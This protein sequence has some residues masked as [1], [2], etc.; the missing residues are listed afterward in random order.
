MVRV[1]WP[2]APSVAALL[3]LGR[4]VPG[5]EPR[6]AVDRAS[7]VEAMASDRDVGQSVAILA[8]AGLATSSLLASVRRWAAEVDLLRAATG[9]VISTDRESALDRLVAAP[10]FASLRLR[11]L[12]PRHALVG[13]EAEFSRAAD[14]L[15]KGGFLLVSGVAPGESV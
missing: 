3:R 14:R 4:P 5:S 12:G 10:E 1:K 15:R 13:D 7:V 2:D 9:V 11:R 6:F 8:S